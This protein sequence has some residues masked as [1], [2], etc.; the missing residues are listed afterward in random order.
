MAAWRKKVV[1]GNCCAAWTSKY[2]PATGKK[3][4]GAVVLKLECVFG[5]RH[6][7]EDRWGDTHAM[8]R[9]G[10]EKHA[11]KNKVQIESI[12]ILFSISKL[13]TGWCFQAKVS[14]HRPHVGE[15]REERRQPCERL[16]HL[17][18]SLGFGKRRPA[19]GHL[20]L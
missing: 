17:G 8:R 16:A 20:H 19:Q 15:L 9:L 11:H 3:E 12:D 13:E 2:V 4:D 18:N 1:C 10:V 6:L 5:E 7:E 14:L